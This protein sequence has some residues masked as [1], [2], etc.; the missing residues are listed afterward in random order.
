MSTKLSPD[1]KAL[2][3]SQDIERETLVI[4]CG[5]LAH[6]ILEIIKLNQ[7]RHVALQCLPA[8]LH[9]YPDKIVDAVRD[10]IQKA[11]KYYRN[12]MVAYGDCGTGGAL[13][14][15]LREENVERIEG[16]HCY[17]FFSGV[18]IFASK[19]ENDDLRAFYLTDFLAR[20]FDA[21]VTRPLGLDRRPE[22]RDI[23]FE[24]YEKIVYLA[25]TDDDALDQLAQKAAFELKL[26]Y[27]RRYTGYGALSDFIMQPNIMPK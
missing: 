9:N 13:D 17:A 24:H 3:C 27:E 4:G 18:D 22:L 15:M 20:H 7:L 16:A 8:I 19:A 2:F 6:E 25:Q 1:E 5:A 11:R 21:F 23:Y 10:E 14:R 12:I 26:D